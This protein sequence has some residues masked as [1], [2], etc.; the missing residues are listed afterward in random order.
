[1]KPKKQPKIKVFLVDDHPAVREGVG[2]YLTGDG[3]VVV[4]GEAADDRE[5]LRKL[6][7]VA[8]DVIVLDINL[9]GVDGGEL[10]KRLRQTVPRAKLIAFSIHA[11]QEYVVR[12]A[13][14]GVH[15]YVMKDMPTA[16]LVE[17]IQR[18]HKG[19]LYFPPGMTDA[20]LAPGSKP[21]SDGAKAELTAREREVLVLLAE[22]LANKEVARKLGIS[23][24]TA[25]THREHL[26]RKLGIAPIAGLTKYAIQHGLTPLSLPAPS[27]P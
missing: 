26:S 16:K 9:P 15:G 19:G 6:K 12:M 11:S 10:A 18:V 20:I 5:A 17:A 3:S 23:V 1:M 7:K 24:R 4:V 22:G 27:E 14:C 8:P 21:S 13:R 25:E 2:S